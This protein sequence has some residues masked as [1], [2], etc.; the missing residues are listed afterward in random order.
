VRA[1]CQQILQVAPL[2]F[3]Q[4]R[5]PVR[6]PQLRVAGCAGGPAWSGI[7]VA[8]VSLATNFVLMPDYPFSAFSI[9]VPDAVVMWALSV[10]HPERGRHA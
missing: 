3:G 6:D 7:L 9:I 8:A 10:Y 4:I 5:G 1:A 2:V